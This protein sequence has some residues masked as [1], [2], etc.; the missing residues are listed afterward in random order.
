MSP[1]Q[2][3]AFKR[4]VVVNP[5]VALRERI[6]L[7]HEAEFEFQSPQSREELYHHIKVYSILVGRLLR[8]NNINPGPRRPFDHEVIV[9]EA[10]K[11]AHFHGNKQDPSK[12]IVLIWSL[13]S[14]G[15]AK[16]GSGRPYELRLDVKDQGEGI[17]EQETQRPS[18]KT[19]EDVDALKRS[20]DDW[21]EGRGYGL[22]QGLSLIA[23][24]SD[25]HEHVNK[26]AWM[27]NQ[28]GRKK[29]CVV[30]HTHRIIKKYT[31]SQ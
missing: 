25:K 30:G 19:S 24:L 11:N 3:K 26:Y 21:M 17:R 14:K 31:A 20:A 4:R 27:P 28:K 8:Q 15:R 7:P 13:R 5:R 29:L 18:L 22:G 6:L 2:F 1:K 9:R 16:A 12:R 23:N 10:L